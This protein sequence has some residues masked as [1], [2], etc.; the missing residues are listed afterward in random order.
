[1]KKTVL[2]TGA[3]G[4]L[5]SELVRQ[6]LPYY[7]VVAATS[8]VEEFRG[9]YEHENL[10]VVHISNLKD[11][12]HDKVEILVNCA[13]PRTSDP[14]KLAEGIP[15]TENLILSAYELGIKAFINISSQ[16]VYSQKGQEIPDEMTPVCPE[17]LYGVTK[18]ATERI[19]A[20]L[21]EQF[22]IDY[23]NIRLASLAGLDFNVRMTNRFV[24]SVV[25]DEQIEVFGGN[26]KVSYLEVRDAAEA[27]TK[28]IKVESSE[29]EKIYNLG[30]NKYFT[31]L[32][33]LEQV[34]KSAEKYNLKEI[35][36]VIK[37]SNNDF[38]NLLKSNRFYKDFNWQ[39][40]YQM[41]EIVEELFRYVLKK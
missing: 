19:I 32:E 8:K 4:L 20:N 17:S 24:K 25:N 39:P 36:P 7:K 14:R 23:S 15:F 37:K 35:Q 40:S 34:K 29:W 41:V 31:I 30:N 28:M 1:M 18:Y 2:V 21:C 11:T 3:G 26:Q 9:E 10:Q 38:N 13:F 6:L 5:G 16:S 12:I 27:L 22:S 33:L